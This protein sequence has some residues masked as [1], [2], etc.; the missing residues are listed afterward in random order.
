MKNDIYAGRSYS[1]DWLPIKQIANGMIE[2]ESGEFVC[3][4]KVH[5]RNIFILPQMERTSII[6]NLSSFYNTIDYEFWLVIV[7][8]P[9]DISAYIAN[10]QVLENSNGIHLAI[11]KMIN[12]DINKANQFVG[13]SYGV[14]D[15]EYYIMFKEKKSEL[16][17]KKLND[18]VGG[19]SGA[20]LT[21]TRATNEDMRMILDN[22]FSDCSNTSFN[23]VGV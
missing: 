10:L 23:S 11:R 7:N 6:N 21:G 17:E 4:V 13:S 20:R 3:A 19:L 14:T 18:I 16:I 1:E 15:T 2:L 8:R 22:F 9:V 5:P 12:E